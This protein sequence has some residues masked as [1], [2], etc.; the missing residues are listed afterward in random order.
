MVIMGTST[1]P[2]YIHSQKS[3][4]SHDEK[5]HEAGEDH[6]MCVLLFISHNG[7]GFGKMCLVH[8]SDFAHLKIH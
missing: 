1:L 3:M 7:T 4:D 5:A 8:T 6:T 2:K